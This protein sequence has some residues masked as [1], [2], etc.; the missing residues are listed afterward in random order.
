MVYSQQTLFIDT[1][2]VFR[3]MLAA[4]YLNK[5]T[6]NRY[7]AYARGVHDVRDNYL[8]LDPDGAHYPGLAR[9]PK[10]IAYQQI[11]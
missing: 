6:G 3:S 7:L 9:T 2:G 10:N 8:E 1:S 5:I 4:T 11:W